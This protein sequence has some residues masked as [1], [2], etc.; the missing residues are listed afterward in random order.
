[1][2]AGGDLHIQRISA[3]HAALLL[4][5]VDR[6][7]PA[8]LSTPESLRAACMNSHCF[9]VTGRGGYLVVA[10]RLVNGCAW[11]EA[12]KGVGPVNWCGVMHELLPELFPTAES[13]AFQTKRRG[14]EARA[15][16]CGWKRAGV[17]M[18]ASL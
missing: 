13:M 17:I 2:H 5:G 18:R 12:I 10:V 7:D 4:A 9:S 15:L 14:L 3:A 16:A 11:V 1:M 6:L 8:G